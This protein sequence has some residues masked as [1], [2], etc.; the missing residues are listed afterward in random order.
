MN[1]PIV[2]I[3]AWILH[4]IGLSIMIILVTDILYHLVKNKFLSSNEK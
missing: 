1:A 4:I 3:Q 2:W